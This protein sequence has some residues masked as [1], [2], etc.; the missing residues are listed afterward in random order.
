MN[1]K[2]IKLDKRYAYYKQFPYLI[3]FHRSPSWAIGSRA[4]SGVLDFDRCRKWF[5]ET[6]NWSQDVETRTEM[7]KSI[8]GMHP[9]D[10]DQLN[11]INQHWAWSCRYQEY[12]IYVS[13]SALTMFRLKWS[14]DA[15]A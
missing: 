4:G 9:L 14:N 6:W 15:L 12:R 2:I 3:E 13:E 10:A 7:V 11:T 5:N 8:A 1:Y